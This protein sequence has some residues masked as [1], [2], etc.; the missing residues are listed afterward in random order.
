M[1]NDPKAY[2]GN[3]TASVRVK[4]P[5]ASRITPPLAL[6]FSILGVAVLA[7][8]RLQERMDEI[9]PR[10]ETRLQSLNIS[11]SKLRWKAVFLRV[12]IFPYDYVVRK[13]I[14]YLEIK[15]SQEGSFCVSSQIVNFQYF[16]YFRWH[17]VFHQNWYTKFDSFR[18]QLIMRLCGWADNYPWKFS[19]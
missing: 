6:I 8:C 18:C 17:R 7:G 9:C 4:V 10:S 3:C 1:Q 2:L 14:W 12:W 15:P 11:G 5:A 16:V 19:W 13:Q